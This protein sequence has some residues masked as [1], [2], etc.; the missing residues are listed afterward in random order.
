[1]T[2]PLISVQELAALKPEKTVIFDCRF[3]LQDPT[4]GKRSYAEGHIPGAY[5]LDLNEHL[6]SPI[7][8]HGGRHPLPDTQKLCAIL[9]EAG[10]SSLSN[11]VVYDD[12]RCAFAARAW[13]ILN[14]LGLEQVQ[15]L[16]GGYSAWLDA[17][18]AVD[19]RSP[20]PQNG[21]FRAQVKAHWVS[22]YRQVKAM[23][24]NKAFALIDAREPKRYRGEEE[25]IDP[26]AGRIPGALNYPWQDTTDDKGF[27]RS[28]L[29]Q[30]SRWKSL[31]RDSRP[32]V[33]CGSGVTACVDIL[34][35]VLSECFTLDDIRLYAGS[36]SDWCSYGDAVQ[37]SH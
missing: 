3:S 11:I 6:S 36:W 1:M 21:Q 2:A 29:Y 35:L 15:I 4:Y 28:E 24:G 32:V 23:V 34:S 8:P 10:V 17:G 9:S 5:R 7:K 12:Q 33:Y 18:R 16:N 22:D 14:Y 25:P 37:Q 30:A 19:K 20:A 27:V 26:V 13:W 31:P